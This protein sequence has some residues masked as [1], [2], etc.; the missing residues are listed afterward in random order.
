MSVKLFDN[1]IEFTAIQLPI[2]YNLKV[3]PK[4]IG[5]L[6]KFETNNPKSISYIVGICGG[7]H[8]QKSVRVSSDDFVMLESYMS[9]IKKR[10]ACPNIIERMEVE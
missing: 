8:G 6:W 4:D 7:K 10:L 2:S 3:N 5:S 1:H 9:E